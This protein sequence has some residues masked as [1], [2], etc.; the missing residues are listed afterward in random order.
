VNSEDALGMIQPGP[1]PTGSRPSHPKKPAFYLPVDEILNQAPKHPKAGTAIGVSREGRS[2][3]AFR[4]GRGALNVSL[5]GGCHADEPVGPWMLRRLAAH[6][7][8][9]GPS[10]PLLTG[11]SW[12]IVPH[13]NPDGEAENRSWCEPEV[14]DLPPDAGFDVARYLAGV[15]REPPGED[16]EF[17]FPRPEVDPD[18]DVR[19]E[20]RAVAGFLEK[21]ASRSGPFHLHVSFHGM[22]YAGGP[23][24]LI[25]AA[26]R[27]RA[28]PLMTTLARQVAD[29]GY[30]LHDVERR[31]E[32]GFHRIARGFCTR[33]DS[34]SMA[35]HFQA[36]NDPDTAA[37]FRPS[38]MEYVRSLGGDPLTL[39]SEM[40][41][42]ILKGMGDAIE[43]A[44]PVADDFRDRI[45]PGLREAVENGDADLDRELEG[46]GLTAM[47][48]VEQMRLQLLFLEAGLNLAA[49]ST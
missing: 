29:L 35:R 3:R 7:A 49:T 40:P 9:V 47:P 5:I 11:A 33:P 43:P 27:D 34:A 37:K 19:P 12:N 18:D 38:S 13:V 42:F 25:D 21:A 2:V 28:A 26:W 6:L 44:D 30:P 24:F 14:R 4:F 32:K 45:L 31:G 17:G 15:I 1:E 16:I 39:V 46:A 22:A 8:R 10:D 41:L 23:W 20:N 36:R 48:I